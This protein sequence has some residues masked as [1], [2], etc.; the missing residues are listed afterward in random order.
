M[1][2]VRKVLIHQMRSSFG[3]R[4]SRTPK[5]GA[6]ASSTAEAMAKRSAT[7]VNGGM[8][9]SPTRIT[10]Q[11]ELQMRMR[12]D[13]TTQVRA[14]EGFT[15]GIDLVQHPRVRDGL[16]QVRQPG[17]PGHEALDPH[18]EAAV[19]EGPVLADV[20]IPLEG[21]DRQVVRLNT[22]QQ[23]IMIVDALAAADDLAVPFG[24]QQVEA[25]HHVRVLRVGLHVEGLERRREP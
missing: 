23:Q 12:S 3:C 10:A 19:R 4:P 20:E 13:R 8:P 5:T 21:L 25:E 9:R 7:P 24:R 15:L 16:A 6:S 11:V 18:A 22:L 1:V 17:H 14:R 2:K